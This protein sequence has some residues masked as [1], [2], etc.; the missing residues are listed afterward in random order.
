MVGAYRCP[1]GCWSAIELHLLPNRRVHLHGAECVH[2]PELSWRRLFPHSRHRAHRA[3][4][5]C[6][7]S[8][9]RTNIHGDERDWQARAFGWVWFSTGTGTTGFINNTYGTK[10][11]MRN[12]IDLIIFPNGT[13]DPNGTILLS[14]FDSPAGTNNSLG[15]WGSSATPL[16]LEG[17]GAPGDSG[18]PVFILDRRGLVHR[19]RA[20][21][22]RLT[23]DRLL[24]TGKPMP[25][26]A[27]PWGP[28][29]CRPMQVGLT[30]LCQNPRA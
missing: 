10:R 19:R 30:P 1:C 4:R 3:E 12:I 11:A 2:S 15:T 7:G 14:D 27:T 17:M 25:A 18:G 9:S 22:H 5:P 8:D 23:L 24:A 21:L 29:A 6:C 20:F 16:D 26:T 13:I 28:R